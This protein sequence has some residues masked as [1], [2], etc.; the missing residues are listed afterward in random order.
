MALLSASSRTLTSRSSVRLRRHRR[1]TE[2]PPRP[3]GRRGRNSER[4]QRPELTA[5]PLQSRPNASPFWIMLLLSVGA[6]EHGMIKQIA[7][8]LQ[9]STHA[10]RTC[11]DE[12]TLTSTAS[13]HVM[14]LQLPAVTRRT[15]QWN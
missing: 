8:P 15:S 3:S 10:D 2:A 5:L 12:H 7:A 14:I 1:T 4:P 13:E 9:N 6:L 11:E